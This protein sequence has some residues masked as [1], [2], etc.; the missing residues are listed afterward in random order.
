MEV[1]VNHGVFSSD[2]RTGRHRTA[3]ARPKSA[4]P[5]SSRWTRRATT[6]SASTVSPIVAPANLALDG[7]AD[8]RAHLREVLDGLPINEEFDWVERVSIEL[9]TQMLATL[10]DFPFEDRHL[11]TWWSDDRHRR[12]RVG[13]GPV[14]PQEQRAELR[15]CA[16]LLHASSGTSASTRRRATT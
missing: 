9:T 4:S 7:G 15:Q 2:E 8:P 10:F 11:L 5:V 16:G 14:D 6:S 12:P 1:E 3:R 13:Q